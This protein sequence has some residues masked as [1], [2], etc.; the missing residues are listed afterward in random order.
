MRQ[1]YPRAI[2][3]KQRPAN[4]ARAELDEIRQRP[5][6]RDIVCRPVAQLVAQVVLNEDAVRVDET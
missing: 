4:D 5:D 1:T 6:P 3:I 2:A